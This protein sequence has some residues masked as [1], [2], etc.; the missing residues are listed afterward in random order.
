[1][2]L[3]RDGR[4]SAGDRRRVADKV[5]AKQRLKEVGPV[6][7]ISREP[8]AVVALGQR[9]KVSTAMESRL[10]RKKTIGLIVVAVDRSYLGIV[11]HDG[12]GDM[13][14]YVVLPEG[15]ARDL[16]RPSV[17]DDVAVERSVERAI[18]DDR[19]SGI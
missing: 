18:A 5:V 4:P 10:Q 8:R 16:G 15:V 13:V 9:H 6:D 19:S 14:Q 1:M 3:S 2:R 12:R 7:D 11:R 17:P